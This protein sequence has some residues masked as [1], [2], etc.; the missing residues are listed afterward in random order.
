MK[1]DNSRQKYYIQ[2]HAERGKEV[3]KHATGTCRIVNMFTSQILVRI[4]APVHFVIV[5]M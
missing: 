1:T 2:G 4:H 3:S 5:R